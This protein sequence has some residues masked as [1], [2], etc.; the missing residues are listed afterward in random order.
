MNTATAIQVLLQFP[1][2]CLPALLLIVVAL[3]QAFRLIGAA[4]ALLRFA[5]ATVSR[6]I[7]PV[8]RWRFW[9]LCCFKSYNI[10]R[11]DFCFVNGQAGGYPAEQVEVFGEEVAPCIGLAE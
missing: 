1:G 2:F 10:H 7:V 9:A 8:W 4:F 11:L 5:W 3:L 6:Y